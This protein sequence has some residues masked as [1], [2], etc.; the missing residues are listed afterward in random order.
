MPRSFLS[1]VGASVSGIMRVNRAPR[2]GAVS[3]EIDPPQTVTILDQWTSRARCR[4]RPPWWRRR[5][6]SS[7]RRLGRHAWAVVGDRDDEAAGRGARLDAYVTLPS[8]GIRGVLQQVG[9]HLQQLRHVELALVEQ[10]VDALDG[11]RDAGR[12]Q[13]PGEAHPV[14]E[15]PAGW[16]GQRCC[17]AH[18]GEA[19]NLPRDAAGGACAVEGHPKLFR[20]LRVS[21]GEA[22]GQQVG[23]GDDRLQQV[24]QLMGEACGEPPQGSEL[25]P[26]PTVCLRGAE[27]RDVALDSDIGI[28]ASGTVDQRREFEP[29]GQGV[30]SRLLLRI[31]H[32]KWTRV[33][34][35]RAQSSHRGGIGIGTLEDAAVAADHVTRRVA[36]RAVDCA[37]CGDDGP[38]GL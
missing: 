33:V 23:I 1:E 27:G 28:E 24:V 14:T 7:R 29:V 16:R 32:E 36:G 10:R 30:P 3:T 31:S 37:V 8:H 11:E 38:I 2:P 26:L 20:H 9:E 34:E 18:A 19:P 12:K 13:P 35:R 22:R 25:L 17:C 21:G 5:A 15:Q 4:T 6:R